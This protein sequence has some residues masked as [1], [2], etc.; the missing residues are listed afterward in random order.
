MAAE[1]TRRELLQW[2]I[3]FYLTQVDW[4]SDPAIK[5]TGDGRWRPLPSAGTR[6]RVQQKMTLNGIINFVDSPTETGINEAE[7]QSAVWNRANKWCE[8]FRF[9]VDMGLLRMRSKVLLGFVH[10]APASLCCVI[11]WSGTKADLGDD[12]HDALSRKH[13][14]PDAWDRPGIHMTTE[15]WHVRHSLI[16]TGGCDP[17]NPDDSDWI[18]PEIIGA[19]NIS[20][21]VDILQFVCKDGPPFTIDPPE[22]LY[23]D[24]EG[25]ML[26]GT[27][28]DDLRTDIAANE[29][30]Y[31]YRT[32]GVNSEPTAHSRVDYIAEIKAQD[33]DSVSSPSVM[34]NQGTIEGTKNGE[35]GDNAGDPRKKTKRIFCKRCRQLKL[36]WFNKIQREKEDIPLQ[37]F[38]K[39]FFA[40]PRKEVTWN[41]IRKGV[42]T[43]TTWE[44]MEKKFRANPEEWEADYESLT[45]NLRGTIGGH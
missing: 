15:D 7:R 44:A 18:L 13:L 39:E 29:I 33:V 19:S 21:A 40:K 5:A 24:R 34:P 35:S 41:P 8:E 16:T 20:E 4:D 17:G 27:D 14:W 12:L 30:V 25:K 31:P 38:L 3:E 26:G 1:Q 37:T 42:P 6:P 10:A 45:D 9:L 43:A 36:N 28:I 11:D 23:A 22:I 2:W 32:G